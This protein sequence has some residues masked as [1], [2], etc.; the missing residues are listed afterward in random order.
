MQ[1]VHDL[2]EQDCWVGLTHSHLDV[3][4]VMDKVRNPQAG[5][6]VLFA[7]KQC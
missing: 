2:N 6:I 1:G 4:T 3:Q 7:G 5:A